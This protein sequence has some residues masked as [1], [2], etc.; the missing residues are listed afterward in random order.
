MNSSELIA[1][2]RKLDAETTKGP[3]IAER[4]N[5]MAT[6]RLLIA[7]TGSESFPYH[8]TKAAAAFIARTRTLLPQLADAL[9]AALAACND[10]WCDFNGKVVSVERLAA[11]EAHHGEHHEQPTRCEYDDGKHAHG[12]LSIC[13]S[14]RVS[15]EA[16]LAKAETLLRSLADSVSAANC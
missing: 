1:E 10:G 3:W 15:L 13:V 2:A 5:V 4:N 9:A 14:C 6:E 16:R 12:G 7:Y 11:A 8:E